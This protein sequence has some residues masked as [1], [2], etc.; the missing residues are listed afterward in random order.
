M[1]AAPI[2]F[3]D[4]A[5]ALG[6]AEVGLLVWL[7]ALDRERFAPHVVTQRGRLAE[8][9]ARLDVA[10]H[11]MPLGR[12]RGR[13]DAVWRLPRAASE[14]AGIIRRE[15]IALVVGNTVRASVYAALAARLAGRPFVWHVQD[16][17]RRGPY[18]R[19]MM[20]TSGAVVAISRAVAR[21][22]PAAESVVVV[23]HGVVPGEFEADRGEQAR[24][25]RA[26]W[27]IPADA[28]LLG[29]V[30][31]LQ[32]WKG[33]RDVI[34]AVQ[35]IGELEGMR[36]AIIGGDIFADARSYQRELEESVRR[37]GL[38][39]RVIFTG[40]QD[41][42]PTT[43]RTLD[44]VVH[45]SDNEPFGRILIEA[46]AAA[47]PV[48]G[49]ASGAVEE[50]VRHEATGLLVPPS[51]VAALAAALRRVAVDRELRQR[52]G[53]AARERIRS[54]FDA[55]QITR[56]IEN[57]FAAVIEGRANELPPPSVDATPAGPLERPRA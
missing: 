19:F 35:A 33:Q 36:V 18:V 42:M 1:S 44:A 48:V 25:L 10:V 3:V 38:E 15:R 21:S 23:P 46:G 14:I 11:E 54:E 24:K 31:R 39:G 22:L 49:Y 6:G 12:L 5:T 47:L 16:I 28:V 50:I 32:P 51:D 9:A 27:G 29:H 56:R 37:R 34:A 20:G 17:L 41:D 13:P 7:A 53:T 43:L 30:A 4:H 55:G 52:L 26:S 8:S 2:L 57:V 45:A 40:H